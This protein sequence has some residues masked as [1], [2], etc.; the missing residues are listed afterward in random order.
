MKSYILFAVLLVAVTVTGCGNHQHEHAATEGEHVHE[1]NLQ[2]TATT[3]RYTRKLRLLS[4]ERQATFLP[5]LRS[6]K[7]SNRSKPAR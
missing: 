4:L 1:E 6:L 7:I 3:S 5:I 2:L